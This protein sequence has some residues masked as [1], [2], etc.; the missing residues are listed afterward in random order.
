M[1]KSFLLAVVAGVICFSAPA[2]G[3]EVLTVTVEIERGTFYIHGESI[4]QVPPDF[5]FD[6]LMDYEN[7]HR[8]SSGIAETRFLEPTE[9]G[10]LLGYTRI[11]SC[12]WFFCKQVEKVE[13][14]HSIA[15]TEIFTE[16]I[17]EQSDFKVNN[18]HWT[19]KPV[20]GGT[21]A[22]YDVTMDPDFWIPPVIGRWALKKKLR[23]SAEQLG[24]RIEYIYQTGK[25][26]SYYGN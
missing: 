13:R 10:V 16:A 7:F 9:D 24:L 17:P 22:T 26:L 4:I 15:S 14:I 2:T 11:D 12:I 23:S 18:T 19:F 25:P 8:I 5:V 20:E 21:L 3:T 1:N 6:I